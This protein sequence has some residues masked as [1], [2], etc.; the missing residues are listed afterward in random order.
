MSEPQTISYESP[1]ANLN[2][3]GI[4]TMALQL[5]GIVFIILAV[6]AFGAMVPYLTSPGLMGG[7]QWVLFCTQVAVYAVVG[8]A[9]IRLAPRLSIWL[10]G[11]SANGL[12]ARPVTSSLGQSIQAIAF[13]V[14]GVWLMAGA[15]PD[16]AARVAFQ[17]QSTNGSMRYYFSSNNLAYPI[18]RL[19]VGLAL[20]LGSKALS[21]FWHR[22][23]D[24]APPLASIHSGDDRA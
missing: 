18:A 7:L 9:I 19:V 15:L 16:V 22:L 20:F 17:F 6:T 10:F 13:S 8:Y 24:P 12:M 4:G 11:N 3:V 14:I 2:G 1:T 5:V 23:R 21:R